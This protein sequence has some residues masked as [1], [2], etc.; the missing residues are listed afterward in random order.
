MKKLFLMMAVALVTFTACQK[1][2]EQAQV[3]YSIDEVYA[4]ADEL[5]GD[6]IY[7]EGICSHLCK[8]GGRKAFLMGSDESRILRVEGAKMGNFAPEC[9]NNLVRVRGVLHAIEIIPEECESTDG[10]KHG[11]DDNGCETEKKAIRKYFAEAVSY[12]IITE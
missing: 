6:T 9:I 7:F 12:E 3:V 8:H 10:L 11:E 1:Q 5:A 4:Q 2:A